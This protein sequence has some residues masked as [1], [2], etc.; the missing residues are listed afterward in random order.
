M[1]SRPLV[2]SRTEIL[3]FRR[4]VSALDERLP[5]G[6]R[7]LRH[8]AW[9]GLQDSMPRAALLSLHARVERVRAAT[10]EHASLAQLWGPRFSA[11]VVAARDVPVFTLGRLP[12][13]A[14]GRARASS[15]AD[16]L[17]AFLGER[18]IPFGDAGRGLG[19]PHN[20]L[21]YAA[22]TGRVLMRWDG[23]RQPA[24]WAVPPPEV[25]PRDARSE[26]ARRYLHVFGPATPDAFGKWAGLRPRAARDAFASL[27]ADLVPA[28]TPLGDAWLLAADEA[29]ARARPRA[30]ASARLLP[31]GDTYFLLWGADRRLL[32]PDARR[33][34]ALWT[35]RVWP[36]AVLSGGEIV[37]TWRRAAGQVA[38]APWQRLGPRERAAV[39]AEAL[40]LPLPGLERA[41]GV[42]WE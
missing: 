22:A 30:P 31:S 29:A 25:D 2:L 36:G 3:A 9:C 41:I 42:R 23:A 4:G 14:R 34:A 17:V 35:S 21:R 1:S 12:D 37:G 11:Y 26:L 16:R 38:I 8:A 20:S 15:T 28:R 33:R 18:R 5:Y 19:V 27:H 32:V 40:S 7:S 13:D 6:A 24:I 39:E 10:W